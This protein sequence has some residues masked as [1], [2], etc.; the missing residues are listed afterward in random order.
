MADRAILRDGWILFGYFQDALQELVE[1]T[2]GQANAAA[3]GA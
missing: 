2:G 3:G 1:L